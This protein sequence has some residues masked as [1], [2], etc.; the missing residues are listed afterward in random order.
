MPQNRTTSLSPQV[1]FNK[2]KMCFEE[3]RS[4]ARPK[5]QR[6]M[7]GV[8]ERPQKM[9][10]FDKNVRNAHDKSFKSIYCKEFKTRVKR[11]KRK[12]LKQVSCI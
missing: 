7:K 9:K 4:K 3:I 11:V 2:Y 12:I 1:G 10:D 5:L 6:L 8:A